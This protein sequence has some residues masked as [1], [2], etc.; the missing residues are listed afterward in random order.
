MRQGASVKAPRRRD[1]LKAQTGDV[2]DENGVKAEQR[3]G[4]RR[5]A[6]K[7]EVQE[8]TQLRA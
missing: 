6:M 4:I 5:P 3:T 1:R 7:R 8:T 2:A